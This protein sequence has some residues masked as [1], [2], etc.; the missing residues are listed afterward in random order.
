M[1]AVQVW[2]RGSMK[3]RDMKA[4]I[5]GKQLT[6][7]GGR[8]LSHPV[9]LEEG[10]YSFVYHVF[11]KNGDWFQYDIYGPDNYLGGANGELTGD[12]WDTDQVEFD[13]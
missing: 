11:G 13:V 12:G 6:W 7:I 2:K 4:F 10:E 8:D 3:L 1:A 5:D 9:D